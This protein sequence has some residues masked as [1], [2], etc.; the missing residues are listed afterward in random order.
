MD[1]TGNQYVQKNVG[2]NGSDHY[3]PR[4]RSTIS[5]GSDPS[6]DRRNPMYSSNGEALT[7][8]LSQY[9]PFSSTNST[10]S[11][12]PI[13]KRVLNSLGNVIWPLLVIFAITMMFLRTCKIAFPY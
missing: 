13:P 3:C 12:G 7:L 11:P 1:C 2:I 6:L 4:S 10:S 8:F 5:S 9:A